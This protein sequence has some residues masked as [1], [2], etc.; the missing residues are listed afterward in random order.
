MY[1]DTALEGL[2]KV[3]GALAAYYQTNKFLPFIN[4]EVVATRNETYKE[5]VKKLNTLVLIKVGGEPACNQSFHTKVGLL[6][7]RYYLSDRYYLNPSWN[8]IVVGGS[9]RWSSLSAAHEGG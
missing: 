3:P 9:S 2:V 7:P 8:V 5:R 1:R 6:E 4:N